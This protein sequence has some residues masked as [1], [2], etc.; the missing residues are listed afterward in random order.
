MASNNQQSN[1]SV[2]S[3]ASP[4]VPANIDVHGEDKVRR[5][6]VRDKNR[7]KAM[8]CLDPERAAQYEVRKPLYEWKVECSYMKPQ[9]KGGLKRVSESEQVVAQ[10]EAD[11]WSMFCDKLNLMVSRRACDVKIT[12][13]EKR[14]LEE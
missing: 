9:E 3:P 4:Y 8:D 2:A 10:T 7:R 6:A 5:Q 14:S 11:A 1:Q 12:R 13:L